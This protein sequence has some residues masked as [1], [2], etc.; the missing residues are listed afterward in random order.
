MQPAVP[1][2][3][4]STPVVVLREKIA[5]LLKREATYTLLPSGLTTTATA[6][7]RPLPS[8]QLTPS[9]FSAIQPAVPLNCVN[10][11]V[12]ALR[13]NTDTVDPSNAATYTSL[14]SGLIATQ[15]APFNPRPKVQLPPASLMHPDKP[16]NCVSSPMSAASAMVGK[17]KY[18]TA[19]TMTGRNKSR[20]VRHH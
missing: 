5:T 18:N 16:L 8:A 6:P 1:L 15:P 4:V 10:T 3:C 2:S 9:P 17:Q 20:K 11:P 19:A 13:E 7:D 14:P 12:V